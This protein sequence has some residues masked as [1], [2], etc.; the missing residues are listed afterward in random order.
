MYDRILVPADGSEAAAAASEMAIRL[1]GAFDADLHAVFVEETERWPFTFDEQQAAEMREEGEEAISS[2]A[3][4]AAEAGIE[5]TTA[6]LEGD[7]PV[8]RT[9]LAYADEHGIDCLVMGT[10]GRTGIDRLLI[11]SVTEKLLRESTLPVVTVHEETTVGWPFEE[12]LVP[13]DGSATAHAALSAAIELAKQTDA[14]VHLVHVVDTG[15]VTGDVDGGL[16][17]E[18]LEEAGEQSL[19]IAVDRVEQSPVTT[20]ESVILSGS[21][22]HVICDYADE[23]GVDAI[24]MGT[25]GRTGVE[26]ALLGSVAEGVIRRSELPVFTTKAA[27]EA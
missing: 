20:V 8:H 22:S 3:D 24:V 7:D 25:H 9:L 15:V 6:V 21:P 12:I 5:A 4:R 11:G 27:R 18:A 19:D 23:H 26:R 14:T 1:A 17:L 13:V 16:V 10:R 2:V